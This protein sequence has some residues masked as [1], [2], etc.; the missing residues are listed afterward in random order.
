MTKEQK[1]NARKIYNFVQTES[2]KN[3][4]DINSNIINEYVNKII[5]SN[6]KI[7]IESKLISGMTQEKDNTN[8]GSGY[9]F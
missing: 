3:A 9:G 1:D 2:F 4:L 8:I 5:N 7:T 6:A